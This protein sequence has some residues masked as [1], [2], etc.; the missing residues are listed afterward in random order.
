MLKNHGYYRV[1]E[2]DAVSALV[3]SANGV[4]RFYPPKYRGD[5]WTVEQLLDT[6]AS[7][8]TMVDLDED[9]NME[10]VVLSPF[11]GDEIKIYKNEEGKYQE[12]YQYPE[13]AEFLHAI[14]S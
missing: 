14:W 3:C 8:A 1:V 5:Q 4:F 10:L 7:D 6:P 13:K 2:H 11:H 12:V 9:G